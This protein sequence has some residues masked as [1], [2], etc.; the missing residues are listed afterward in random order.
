MKQSF[1]VSLDDKMLLV[2]ADYD[3][4]SSD[5]YNPSHCEIQILSCILCST[6]HEDFHAEV[7]K[8]DYI[9]S[10]KERIEIFDNITAQVFEMEEQNNE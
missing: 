5:F 8:I 3:V 9:P 4:Y 10:N 1:F 6:E 7:T 2:E